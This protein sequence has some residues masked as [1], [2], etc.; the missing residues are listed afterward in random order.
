MGANGQDRTSTAGSD[1]NG[2]GFLPE[3][4][5]AA[6]LIR[7]YDWASTPLGH[8][9]QW[10]ASLR[11]VVRFILANR[12]PMLLWWGPDYIQ[13][14]NDNYAPILGAKHPRQAMGKPFRECWHEVYHV[15]GPLVDIPY[16][17]GPSSWLD[18]MELIVRR[19]GFPEESHFTG[20]YSPVPDDTAPRGIGGVL[21]TIIESTEKVIAERRVKILSELGARVAEAKTDEQACAQAAAILAQHPKD[22]PFALFYLGDDATR[23][24]RL[25]STCGI[26]DAL[27]GPRSIDLDSPMHGVP[28]PLAS[29]LAAETI[30]LRDDLAAVLPS[31]PPGPWA[32]A[33]DTVA[34]LPIKSNVAGRPAGALV[35]GISACIRL[36][37][38]Y[39]SF[40]ELVGSQVAT[41]VANARAY[42]EERRRAEALAEI[43]R[44]KTIFF[45]NVS[46]EFRTPLTLMLGPLADALAESQTPVNVRTHLDI[47]QRNAQRLL[48][49]VNSLLDFAR[50]EAGRI[51]ASYA[52]V[53]LGVLTADLSSTFRSAMERAGLAFDVTCEPLG[54]LVY[55][56]REMWE[57][58]VLNLLSN[59]FKF[60]LQGTVSVRIARSNDRAILEVADTGVGVP[61]HELPRL[62]DRFH[63]VEHT[64]ARTHEG[65][66]IGLAMVQELVRLHGGEITVESTP[67]AGTTFRVALPFGHA[68][69]PSDRIEA[70]T[71]ASP[72]V[73]VSPA[74]VGTQ[75]YVQEALRWLP[76]ADQTPGIAPEAPEMAR[77]QRFKSTF[78]SRIVLADDNAD[79]RAYIRELLGRFYQVETAADGREALGAIQR[80]APDLLLADVM[81]P[82][83]DGFKLLETLRAQREF[84]DIPVI[85][86][87]ARAG[88]EARIEGLGAGADDYIVK[89]FHARELLARV[90]ALLELTAIRRASE[91]RFRAFVQAT[92]DVVYRMSPDWREMRFLAGRSFIADQADPSRTWLQKYIHPDDQAAVLEAI[93]SAIQT[94]TVFE[95]EH[96]V[97]RVDGSLGWTFSRAIPLLDDAGA[98]V[99][100]FGT[101]S[102][103]TERRE[104]QE[105]ARRA[106]AERLRLLE[107][108]VA[109]MQVLNNVGAVVASDLDREKVV[110]SVTDKATELTAAD[111]GAFF[112][113]VKNE[114]GESYTLYTISG[115]PREAF[116]K[117]PMP[118]NTRVFEATFNGTGVVRSGDITKD[119][120]YG[121]NP[122]HHGMPRGHLPVRSYL[123]V[124]VKGPLGEVIGGLFFGHA[125]VDRF[126]EH[127]ERL[128]VGIGAWASVALEN[129][130]MFELAQESSRLKD[131]F[132]ASL[133]HELRT[134]LNAVLG[135]ARILRAGIVSGEKHDKAIETIERNANSLA[136]IV[137]DVL[138]VSRIISGKI[139]LNVQSVDFP[140]V[141]QN[142]VDAVGPAANAKGV[143]LETVLDPR[144]TP[145]SGDPE[146]L[147]QVFWNLISNAV[148][149]TGR[150]GKVQIRLARV[151]SH[152]EVAVA[153][154]G[155]GISPEFLPHVFDRFRQADASI[156]RERGG[157]GLG[158]SIA[159]Q[160]TEVHGGTIEA[161]SDG[162]GQG[163]TFTVKLPLMVV[164]SAR[165][166]FE[167]VYPGA[168]ASRQTIPR[169]DLRDVHVLAVDDDPDAVRLIEELL[170]AAGARVTTA[171]S[172]DDALNL[173]DAEVPDVIVTDLGMPR[174]D[175]FQFLEKLR[176]HRNPLV[177]RVPAAALTA[178]AR[179]DDRVKALRAGFQFHLA[180]PIEPTEL[181]ATI[182][183]LAKRFDA[184]KDES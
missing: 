169:G 102:D 79:M 13:L 7:E 168:G 115:V 104:M 84:A 108:N 38:R 173:L 131:E 95:F 59:A 12:F 159:R 53:D 150:G 8:P 61:E 138:D 88:E 124:P 18:D 143:R 19:H 70:P 158:L 111:F 11:N 172:T 22:V 179:S 45:S 80:E 113:N 66:G 122:P 43:D 25:V 105:T 132:L 29:A 32:D 93:A 63:R 51:Q 75:A 118:R 178:Y 107:E 14:Y 176:A 44:A 156:S 77:D 181:V 60:T 1:D 161:A 10:S 54:D 28:W 153:D 20:S 4:G 85:L 57:K 33:P 149:F 97:I 72:A 81:M 50:I 139:R 174:V 34:V 6:N 175:G 46:H 92:S 23:R 68:H 154:T 73:A 69:L 74:A 91:E 39:R 83:L 155:I 177:R 182:A 31:V 151:N 144:A 71:A 133:S 58:I 147:Q 94:K 49:L 123:A 128:A 163:A 9:S 112:Y 110:Q 98:I 37:E 5:E 67:G 30:Q 120:R 167:R 130:R 76:D 87:S 180:K 109:V 103:V 42:D 148:K 2:F 35:V 52:P 21:G 184:A 160:L 142:A 56:D 162:L 129:A 16:Q 36:D 171:L 125:G 135:Y 114:A 152:L 64:G 100:W 137:E 82:G 116:S 27:T 141:V 40:L 145:V 96:R 183:A 127:H 164:H 165:E 119:P 86:V 17:G 24:L 117:F 146:R 78:G 55:V 170:A 157:L 48:K 134:P 26:D 41:A 140:E 99:E 65:S 15:L 47:A 166:Q 136:Q 121:H 101:A 106:E 90:G 126:T 62:F 89:P 3:Q